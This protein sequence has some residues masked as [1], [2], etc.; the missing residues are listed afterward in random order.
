MR[1]P[2]IKPAT[3]LTAILTTLLLAYAPLSFAQDSTPE[4]PDTSAMLILDASGS[5]WQKIGQGDIAQTKIE[6]ARDVVDEMVAA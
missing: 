1:K 5:M 4:A 3:K 2:A 6:I